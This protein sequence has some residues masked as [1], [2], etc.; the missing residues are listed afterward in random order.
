MTDLV[1]D[2]WTTEV[3]YGCP[4]HWTEQAHLLKPSAFSRPGE[5]VES[6]A[7]DLGLRARQPVVPGPR[8]GLCS[9]AWDISDTRLAQA[10]AQQQPLAARL[11]GEL[12]AASVATAPDCLNT[13]GACCWLM[14]LV[15]PDWRQWR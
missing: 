15:A 5:S 4:L 7:R 11:L 10:L 8:P 12:L 13:G 14:P 1:G 3:V 9:S 2:A 6:L